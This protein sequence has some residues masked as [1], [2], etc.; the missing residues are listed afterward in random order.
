[1]T[2]LN[3]PVVTDPSRIRPRIASLDDPLYYLENTLTVVNW[4]RDYHGDLLTGAEKARLNQFLAL[5]RPS[6]ALLMRLVM[7]SR[8]LFRVAA[9][10][11]AELGQPV[12]EALAPLFLSGWIDPEPRLAV[13]EVCDLL[14][15]QELATVF[16]RELKNAGLT[17]SA[18][19]G[20]MQAVLLESFPQEHKPLADW[21]PSGGDQVIRL[22]E[23]ALFDRLRLMFFGNL[24]QNWSEFVI[25]ELGHQR[26]ESV[27]FSPDSRAFHEREDVDQYLALHAYR[28]RLDEA[29]TAEACRSLRDQ[30]PPDAGAN[31]WLRHRRARLLFA[32]GQKLERAGDLVLARDVYREAWIPDARVRY[33][34]LLE[35][36]AAATEVWPLIEQAEA[37]AETASE[38]QSLGR[39]RHR[40]GKKVGVSPRPAPPAE[41]PAV[42]TII[43]RPAPELSVEHQVAMALAEKGGHCFYVENTLFTGLFG[44]L[45][46]PAIFAPRPGAFFH[47]FQTG[48]ADLYREDFT[49]QRQEL[50]E[51]TLASLEDGDYRERIRHHWRT[52]QGI[53]NPFVHWPVFTDSVTTL[54]LDLIPASHLK[55]V[56]TRLLADI[57]AH[58]SGLP[59]L[60][61]FL[62]ENGTYE[63]IEVKA[64]GDRLQDHQRLWMAFFAETGIPASVCHVLWEGGP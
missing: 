12:S 48:P 15:R 60:I 18:T 26:Y 6:Q 62:P 51:N 42:Q 57:R 53:T 33:F 23:M 34:R 29:A 3:T 58:R 7:R 9:L 47:P 16:A 8:N 59:D 45:F 40:V 50:I 38:K 25:T 55:A 49:V 10:D 43:L 56:F 31:P 19:K 52:R 13:G 32:L 35:K 30:L 2:I 36:M 21:W 64:P 17:S 14:R 4:V 27:P 5:P 28:Q 39:I 63:L 22:Q 1:M 20:L 61:H 54:A 44:L 41:S 24:R 11:Y 46:W 37:L